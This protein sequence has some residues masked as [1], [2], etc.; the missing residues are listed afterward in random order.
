MHR[1]YLCAGQAAV[2]WTQRKGLITAPFIDCGGRLF[3]GTSYLVDS[4]RSG[5]LFVPIE[6]PVTD[7][8]AVANTACALEI[9]SDA[10]S[11]ARKE[12]VI[13]PCTY[14]QTL[15]GTSLM[16]QRMPGTIGDME[17]EIAIVV[18][19]YLKSHYPF[20]LIDS[21]VLVKVILDSSPRIGAS[22]EVLSRR[23]EILVHQDASF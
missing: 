18:L 15:D 14:R 10:L 1:R 13:R 2:G 5:I 11:K 23:E 22:K 12:L 3:D 7:G 6:V 20:P 16:V 4:P 8:V 9:V 19:N 17:L 21:E